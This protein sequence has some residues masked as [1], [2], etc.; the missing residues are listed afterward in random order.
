MRS[1]VPLNGN[2]PLSAYARA[3]G[4]IESRPTSKG[5]SPPLRKPT[6]LIWPSPAGW[7]CTN[8]R[9]VPPLSIGPTA[10]YSVLM[11]TLPSGIAIVPSICESLIL[12]SRVLRDQELDERRKPPLASL[13]DVVHELEA[14]QGDGAVLLGNTPMRA[15]PTPPERPQACHGVDVHCANA[16]LIFIAGQLASPMVD[17]RMVVAPCLQTGRQAVR[18]RLHTGAGHAGVWA[19]RLHGL[20]L[21]LSK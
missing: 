9:S 14:T 4:V 20:W 10:V 13:A 8:R 12:D 5:S 2:T 11:V 3:T 21:H 7:P 16:V 15:Q 18:V 17:P 19:E 1:I 6:R